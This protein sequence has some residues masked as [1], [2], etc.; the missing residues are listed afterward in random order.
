MENGLMAMKF[1]LPGLGMGEIVRMAD[2]IAS[3]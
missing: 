3:C 2:G 1:K